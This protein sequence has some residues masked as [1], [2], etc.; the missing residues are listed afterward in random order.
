MSGEED[1]TEASGEGVIRVIPSRVMAEPGGTSRSI[2]RPPLAA[3][4]AFNEFGDCVQLQRHPPTN[5]PYEYE[6]P[7]NDLAG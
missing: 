1:A 2:M 7:P 6:V 4:T 5:R 3:V